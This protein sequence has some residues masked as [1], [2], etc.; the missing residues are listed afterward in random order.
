[1][2]RLVGERFEA[3]D[4]QVSVHT[5]YADALTPGATP[6]TIRPGTGKLESLAITDDGVL[7][8]ATE[9]MGVPLTALS[10]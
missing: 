8:Q 6:C 5:I 3:N 7:L 1:M 4:P 9:G 2:P 10:R